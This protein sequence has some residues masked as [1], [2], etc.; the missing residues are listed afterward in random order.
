MSLWYRL[1]P[2]ISD[3]N[4][5]AR[6]MVELQM[7]WLRCYLRRPRQSEHLSMLV[8]GRSSGCK[9]IRSGPGAY[10]R[11]GRP[12]WAGR[13]GAVPRRAGWSACGHRA[14][15][16]ASGGGLAAARAGYPLWDVVLTSAGY[17]LLTDNLYTVSL[18]IV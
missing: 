5:A 11:Y 18:C 10:G 8:T 15:G 1:R 7:C 12:V 6:R 16:R 2:T 3:I 9:N 13:D 4:Y 17:G 14:G